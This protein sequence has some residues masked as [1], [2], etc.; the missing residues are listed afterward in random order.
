MI[1]NQRLFHVVDWNTGLKE[2]F[3]IADSIL[4]SAIKGISDLI[5]NHG[6]INIT[7]GKDLKIIEIENINNTIKIDF[8]IEN[9]NSNINSLRG[10][11]CLPLSEIK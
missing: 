9:V 1:S 6:I 4:Y 10:N 3:R 8:V 5:V 7:A 11:N 2:A